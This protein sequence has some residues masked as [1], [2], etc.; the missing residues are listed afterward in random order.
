MNNF[1]LN[2]LVVPVPTPFAESGAIDFGAFLAH[3]DW[4]A[5]CGV[6]NLFINFTTEYTEHTEGGR[7]PANE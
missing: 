1:K 3:L 4:L 7:V 2:G 6:R 5:E